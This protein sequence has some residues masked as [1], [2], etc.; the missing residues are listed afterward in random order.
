MKFN[1]GRIRFVVPYPVVAVMSCAILLDKDHRIPLCFLSAVVHELGH[2]A[3][4]YAFSIAVKE[5]R[6]GLFDVLIAADGDRGF[7]PDMLITA[8]G[9]FANLLFGVLFIK[10]CKPLFYINLCISIFNLLPLE[11]FDGG[12]MLKLLLERRF[13]PVVCDR[14]IM[15]FSLVF[16][17]PFILIG[18]LVL[19]YS[20]YN[21]SLLLIGSY[22]LAVLYLK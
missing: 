20:K 1:I 22:L 11:T 6:L 2:L 8:S 3:A 16:L 17:V 7:L 13:S 15:I 14:V 21:Y 5:I 4:M 12:H 18:T 19:I 9:P 10:L